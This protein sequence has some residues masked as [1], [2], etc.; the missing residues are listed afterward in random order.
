MIHF[1]VD[2][3][4]R[5]SHFLVGA[6]PYLVRSSGT[7]FGGLMSFSRFLLF[8]GFKFCCDHGS[9][10]AWVGRHVQPLARCSGWVHDS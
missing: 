5:M 10:A 6:P 3:I 1:R 7:G 8:F 4:H 9:T 2:F